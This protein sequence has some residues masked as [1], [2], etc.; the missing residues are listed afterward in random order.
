MPCLRLG[1]DGLDA[2]LS[3][4]FLLKIKIMSVVYRSVLAV[5]YNILRPLCTDNMGLPALMRVLWCRTARHICVGT[6]NKGLA[7]A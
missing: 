6:L 1:S 3:Q 7:V 5:F 2:V 4:S